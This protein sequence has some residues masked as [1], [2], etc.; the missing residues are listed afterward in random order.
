MRNDGVKKRTLMMTKAHAIAEANMRVTV[1][2]AIHHTL[3]VS[4]RREKNSHAKST[5]HTNIGTTRTGEQ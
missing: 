2:I 5:T 3:K 1:N 4:T